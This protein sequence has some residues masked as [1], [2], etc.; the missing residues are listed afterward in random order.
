MP[1]G[2]IHSYQNREA[3]SVDPG[4]R[5]GT[6]LGGRI[7]DLA[8]LNAEL[9][10]D[11]TNA[12]TPPSTTDFSEYLFSFTFSPLFQIP[13]GGVEVVIG[14]K[15]GL[16]LLRAEQN[17][18]TSTT[19]LEGTGFVAGI[20]TGLFVPVSP[21]TSIG[22]MLAFELKEIESFCVN[23]GSGSICDSATNAPTVK[24]IALSAGALF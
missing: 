18:P 22:A 21:S 6:F 4:A 10:V 9:T 23:S 3:S 16:F 13:A 11:I 20:N 19:S 8:S 1:Y 2:G 15:V 12:D 24:L 7:N 5:F 14:P 17:T